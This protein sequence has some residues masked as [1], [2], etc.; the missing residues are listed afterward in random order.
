[1]NKVE[2]TGCECQVVRGQFD[3]NRIPLDCKA[4]WKL[5]GS[6]CTIGVFQLEKRLVA[7]TAQPGQRLRHTQA[8]YSPVVDM[9]TSHEKAPLAR[10][11]R[12]LSHVLDRDGAR[13]AS[14]PPISAR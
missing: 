4:T 10:T 14:N 7:S 9:I 6:G 12:S 8:G 5:I 3:I 2:W 11:D 1:M 13:V